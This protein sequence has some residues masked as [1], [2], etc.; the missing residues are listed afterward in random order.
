VC[1]AEKDATLLSTRRAS[2]AASMTS[3]SRIV[4]DFPFR[5]T[6]QIAPFGRMRVASSAS[7]SS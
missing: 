3:V 4:A 5:E 1:V 2:F 6:T 7:G